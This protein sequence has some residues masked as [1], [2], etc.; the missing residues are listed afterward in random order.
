MY[1]LLFAYLLFSWTC[2]HAVEIAGVPASSE[3][4][5]LYTFNYKDAPLTDVINEWAA[6]KNINIMLPQPQS[7]QAITAKL[8]YAIPGKIT[9]E[10]AWKE[11]NKVLELL[12][13]S[14]VVYNNLYNL[15]K[16]SPDIKREPLPVFVNPHLAELPDNGSVI[17]AIFYL[18]NLKIKDETTRNA[19]DSMLKSMLSPTA[20]IKRDEKTNALILTDKS[21]N[22]RS[23]MTIIQELDLE[24]IPDA[25]EV[26]PLYYTE[27]PFVEEIFKTKLLPTTPAPQPTATPGIKQAAYFPQNTKIIALPRTN[28]IVI[29]G[30]MKAI[31]V[32]KDFLVK[33]IDRPL[34]SGGSIL[35]I[36]DLQYLNAEDFADI[37]QGLVSKTNTGQ[38][39]TQ[40]TG[41]I[42]RDF[43][44]VIIVAEKSTLT[45][46]RAKTAKAGEINPSEAP[47]PSQGA[48]APAAQSQGIEQA[49]NRLL[50]AARHEDWIKIEKIIKEL[51]QPLPQV[52]IEVLVVDL[53]LTDNKLLGNQMRNKEGFN[54]SA[55]T[56]NI[57]FQ[58]AM[59][60]SPVLR[61]E[62]D[63][64]I[65]DP[66]NFETIT[67]FPANA[68][69]A[70]LL[71]AS[72][73]SSDLNLAKEGGVG[74][75][76]ISFNDSSGTWNILQMLKARTNSELIA[77]PYIVTTDNR[78]AS[79]TISQQRLVDGEAVSQVGAIKVQK[80]NVVASTSIDILPRISLNSN[81]VNLNIII[82]V[83]QF[84]P[85][86][87]NRTTRLIQTNANVGNKESLAL[88]GLI[89]LSD[90]TQDQEVP[91]LSKVPI[92]GWLF[93]RRQK[94]KEKNNLM[95]F[96]TP[97]IIYPRD[98]KGKSFGGHETH[99][100]FTRR[101]L[102]I[103]QS[104]MSESVIMDN[105]KDPITRWFFNPDPQFAQRVITNYE[106][107]NN[108]FDKDP[109]YSAC[110]PPTVRPT[111]GPGAQYVENTQAKPA[112]EAQV[113]HNNNPSETL[114]QMVM[115]ESNPLEQ[116]HKPVTS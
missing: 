8:N 39:Q 59:I 50:I 31:R 48:E 105:L 62:I 70:N 61:P 106:Q 107:Q 18:S 11:L 52:A 13:Y 99:H 92:L 113:A 68:L 54:D 89:R 96:I 56:K 43:Q 102:C 46:S 82:N 65:T 20:D 33:Y 40:V 111:Y 22:I 4:P 78:Q 90:T 45:S 83:N 5:L 93:K 77:S 80:E 1:I 100:E 15:V 104:D 47:S 28:N 44:D 6:H 57:N 9:L 21:N 98:Y 76:V 66:T 38:A 108:L 73:E 110:C 84:L 23:V 114:K 75:V 3:A 32:V 101:K 29:M 17:Q 30:S 95:V 42:R 86:N 60:D 55:L 112:Q 2:I 67:D 116:P 97:T 41:G 87:N 53:S 10:Q 71:Q 63:T 79:I 36:Y 12:G 58:T 19:L 115:H 88:G 51:D 103:A 64:G 7:P 85:E 74:S 14:W 16:I 49:G 27:A 81:S 69:M 91:L 34:E 26:V 94:N 35:H 25:L 109:A 24:G 37:L 72:T